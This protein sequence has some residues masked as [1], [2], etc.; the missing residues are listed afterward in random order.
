MKDWSFA[1][2]RRSDTVWGPH[3]YHR[4]PAKFIPQLVRR[5]IETYSERNDLIGDPFVGSATT[6]VE[7][8]RTVCRFLESN[9]KP[10][11]LIISEAKCAALPTQKLE[12]TWKLLN[13]R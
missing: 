7:A 12:K 13:K 10:S 3:G 8:L 4:Y 9:V 11:A 6:G 2:S 1:D 5:V